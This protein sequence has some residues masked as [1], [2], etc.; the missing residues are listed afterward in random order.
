MPTKW[1]Y[2]IF[3]FAG[4]LAAILL[5]STAVRL[6]AGLSTSE[7]PT[8]PRVH[9]IPPFAALV[10]CNAHFSHEILR[11]K[12]HM[13]AH[14][15]AADLRLL[16]RNYRRL[17]RLVRQVGRRDGIAPAEQTERLRRQVKR[18]NAEPGIAD[19][20][21]RDAR[22]RSMANLPIARKRHSQRLVGQ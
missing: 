15:T 18:L 12:N 6:V 20:A 16:H 3:L 4:L 9:T 5:T 7:K 11:I 8:P 2:R 21:A 14:N 17:H 13:P 22:C 19:A 1:Q 10:E